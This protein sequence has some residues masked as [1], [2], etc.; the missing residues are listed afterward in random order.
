MWTC[1]LLSPSLLML[2]HAAI[3]QLY[4]AHRMPADTITVPHSLRLDQHFSR[5]C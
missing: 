1:M 5:V 3:L 2:Q 4:S